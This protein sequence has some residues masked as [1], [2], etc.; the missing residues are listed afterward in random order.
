MLTLQTD[1][2]KVSQPACEVF[3][4]PVTTVAASSMPVTLSFAAANDFFL[5]EE[6]TND[7]PRDID[8]SSPA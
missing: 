7:F 1:Y 2:F 3:L 4:P 8:V 5:E 6:S